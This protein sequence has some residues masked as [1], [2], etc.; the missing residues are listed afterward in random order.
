MVLSSSPSTTSDRAPKFATTDELAECGWKLEEIIL[1]DGNT[2][3][4]MIPLTE[5]EF[6]HPQ[7]GYRLPNS[8]F[9]GT[10]AGDV[11]DMLDRRY[12]NEPQVGIFQDLL[13]GWDSDMPDHCPDVFVAFGIDNKEQNRT[14]FFVDREGARPAFILEVVSPRFRKADRETK[15]VHYAQAGV[16][17]YVICDRRT[18]RKQLTEEVLGYRLRGNHYQPITPD[19]DGRILCQTLGVWISLQSGQIVLEDAETGERLKTS[20][21]LAEEVEE[22]S[23][24]NQELSQE[25][26]ELSQENQELSQENQELSQE[27]QDMTALL[28]R[29]RQ[30]FGDFPETNGE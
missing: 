27:N 30:Q 9:H 6:L 17:E 28:A 1:P 20:Q 3:Y 2:D 18:Y 25:N 22:L 21:E 12:A 23:Q 29:Y 7:E 26:Q 10:V 8:T 19:E 24:E 11:K 4:A 16:Q 5:D 13:V 14:K 15:A